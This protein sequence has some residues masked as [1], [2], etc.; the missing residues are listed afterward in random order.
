MNETGL[1]QTVSRSGFLDPVKIVEINSISLLFC[2][3]YKGFMKREYLSIVIILLCFTML[4][5]PASATIQQTLTT[6]FDADGSTP[7]FGEEVAATLVISAGEND[8]KDLEINFQ[9]LDAY[10]DYNSFK[11]EINPAGA[12]VNI[13]PTANGFFIDS[14]PKG[15]VVTITFNAYPKTVKPDKLTLATIGFSYTQ[16]GQRFVPGGQTPAIPVTA[17]LLESSYHK[18]EKTQ[19]GNL[20]N[21]SG[22]VIG[23]FVG[24]VAIIALVLVYFKKR[25][26]A[27]EIVRVQENKNKLLLELYRKVELAE[28]NQAEYDSLKKR[29]RDELGT[30]SSPSGDTQKSTETKKPPRD[31]SGGFE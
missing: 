18:Y 6:T 11:K 14:L 21:S 30:M 19:G 23:V 25:E 12:S 29:L 13:T 2:F 31:F 1:D 17:D 3:T 8:I 4:A 10:V 20:I 7:A 5:F 9:N 24:I 26:T 22:L 15:V 16:L 28:N 27:L